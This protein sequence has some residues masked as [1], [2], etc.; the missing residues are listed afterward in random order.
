MQCYPANGGIGNLAA[1][2]LADEGFVLDTEGDTGHASLL[3]VYSLFGSGAACLSE[4]GGLVPDYMYLEHEGSSALS[5]KTHGFRATLRECGDGSMVGFTLRE[6]EKATLAS[7]GEKD[8]DLV[9]YTVEGSVPPVDTKAWESLAGRFL[10][11]FADRSRTPKALHTRMVEL[12]VDHH[13]A[14]KE[15]L[16][17]NGFHELCGMLGIDHIAI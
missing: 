12:G 6:M 9:I 7:M 10:G 2:L 1:C 11:A 15:G 14:L 8:G 17:A 3:Y 16:H 13:F 5:L 4:T